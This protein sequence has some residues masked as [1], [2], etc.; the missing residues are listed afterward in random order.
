MNDSASKLHKEKKKVQQVKTN[1]PAQASLPNENPSARQGHEASVARIKQQR[2][3]NQPLQNSFPPARVLHPDC[4]PQLPKSPPVYM[5]SEWMRASTAAEPGAPT[6][7]LVYPH[8]A[9]NIST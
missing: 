9:T 7:I 6:Y 8:P 1:L 2:E 5:S 4:K 3:F